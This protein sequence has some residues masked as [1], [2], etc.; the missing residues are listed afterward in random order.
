MVDGEIFFLLLFF[1]TLATI[2]IVVDIKLN[3]KKKNPAIYC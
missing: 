3:K 1:S 2:Q